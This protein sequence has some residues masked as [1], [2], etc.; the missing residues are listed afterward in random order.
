M[1][2]NPPPGI[3]RQRM[4]QPH[5]QRWGTY[6][7]E[8]QWG[9]V[10]EDYSA[11][12]NAWSYFPHDHARSRVYR[13][14]ED[15]IGGF[16]D[17]QQ[18]LCLAVALWNGQDPILKER[19]F[20]LTNGQGNHGEDVKELYYYLDATP[21]Y[22]YARM[23][24]K[25]PQAAYPYQA[26]VEQNRQRGKLEQEFE[27][28]DTGIFA[29]NR[30][31]DIEIEYAKAAVD[32][33]LLRV[34]AYNRGPAAARLHLLPQ[35]WFRNTWNWFAGVV[36]P[37]LRADGDHR[38]LID[39]AVLGQWAADFDGSQQLLFC[40]NETHVRRVFGQNEAPAGYFK[41][42]FHDYVVHNQHQAVNPER[43][44]T[45]AAGLYVLELA[46][47]GQQS[48]R[49]RL[50]H[51]RDQ[52]DFFADFDELIKTRRQE[53]DA[54]YAEL[55]TG[56]ADADAR[57]IQRQAWAGLLWSK[58]FYY[59]D[60][61]QWLDGDQGQP[62][63]PVARRQGR[64]S[65][66]RHLN[67]ADILSMPDKWEYPWFAA[68]DLAFHCIALATIDPQSAKDQLVMLCRE[69]YMDPNGELPAYEWNFSDVNPP[70]HAWAAWKV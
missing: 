5:W 36:K 70:V 11:D 32:D 66:W 16:C 14:G 1:P 69:W 44:G 23:L 35:L 13:W 8:R 20:G 12:G 6:V 57:L 10:R 3:E 56:I 52:G 4:S 53:A 26:L 2:P 61:P 59:Y 24:Y 55:Q 25:Y 45:K 22:S 41:D 46:A 47:G 58:Q 68:W 65:D 15:G 29:E 48:V 60:I 50:R 7:S 51:R 30:Y 39:H 63:P 27:L 62:P 54:F 21:T 64:N 17:D 40:D 67:N 49:V 31:F 9:T 38:V 43:T 28:L 34:T 33:I 37:S 19:L 42:A 18:T